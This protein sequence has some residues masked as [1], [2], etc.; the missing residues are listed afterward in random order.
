M[1]YFHLA[2]TLLPSLQARS[3][4]GQLEPCLPNPC[5]TIQLS[6]LFPISRHLDV[7]T[8]GV[9]SVIP[10]LQI[11]K[12]SFIKYLYLSDNFLSSIPQEMV[13]YM[14]DLESLYLHGNPWICDCQLKWLADWLREKPGT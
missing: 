7:K 6:L 3:L 14:S 13:T 1:A 2:V 12:T 9:L 5:V 4:Q 10:Y 11:F 8:S